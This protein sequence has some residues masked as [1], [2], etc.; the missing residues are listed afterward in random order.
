MKLTNGQI[1]TAGQALPKLMGQKLPVQTSVRI[2]RLAQEIDI[3]LAVINSVRKNL[4]EQ[5]GEGDPK[6]IQPNTPAM[7]IF[8]KDWGALLA[9]ESD[10]SFGEKIKLPWTVEIEPAILVALEPFIEM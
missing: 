7:E 8:A 6:S 3:H 2:V 9:E 5:Y 1:F 4:I 10:V